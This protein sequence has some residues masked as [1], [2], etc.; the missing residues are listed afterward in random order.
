M[1]IDPEEDVVGWGELVLGGKSLPYG[2]F[3][4]CSDTIPG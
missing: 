3:R 1:Y 4:A 2:L